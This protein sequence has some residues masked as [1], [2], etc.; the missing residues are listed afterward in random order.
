MMQSPKVQRKRKLIWLAGSA[1]LVWVIYLLVSISSSEKSEM[2]GSIGDPVFAGY[3]QTLRDL[4]QI[5]LTKSDD[6]FTLTLSDSGW[7]MAETGGYSVR[8]DRMRA[9]LTGLQ[10]LT[11]GPTKTSHPDRHAAIGLGNPK[12]GGNGVLLELLNGQDELLKSFVLGRKSAHLYARRTGEDQTYQI[13]GALPPFYGRRPWLD[14]D[15]MTLDPKDI[16]SLKLT[17]VFGESIELSRS[18]GNNSRGFKPSGAYVEDQL[19][20]R[21]AASTTAMALSRLS[22][23]NVRPASDLT[24]EPISIHRTETFSGLQVT[25]KA[26]REPTGAFVTLEAESSETSMFINAKTAGWA[27]E[28]SEYDFQDFTPQVL[29]LVLRSSASEP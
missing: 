27:F 10:T 1:L 17:D 8:K 15:L 9:L 13:E 25:L 7:V 11:Y 6:S 26:F 29:T 21:L 20:S 19:V 14:L 5:R 18:D 28:I 2:H 24:T 4:T 16:K 23:I 22:P 12:E 3:S